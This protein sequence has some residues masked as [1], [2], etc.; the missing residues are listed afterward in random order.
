MGRRVDLAGQT[1]NGWEILSRSDREGQISPAWHTRCPR[2]RRELV[3]ETRTIVTSSVCVDCSRAAQTQGD[4]KCR[5]CSRATRSHRGAGPGVRG[6]SVECNACSRTAARNGRAKDGSPRMRGPRHGA[7]LQGP[8]TPTGWC[9]VCGAPF[10]AR[11][12]SGRFRRTCSTLCSKRVPRA[13]RSS[14]PAI[15]TNLLRGHMRD[16]LL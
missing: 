7:P 10:L 11:G 6:T 9:C 15:L 12:G 3:R 5:W 14:E 1:I 4:W 13:S 8:P 16:R 2:C